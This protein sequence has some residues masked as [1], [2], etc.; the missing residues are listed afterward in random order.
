MANNMALYGFR[1]QRSRF[2]VLELTERA[3]V[4]SAYQAAPSAINVDLRPGDPVVKVSDGTVALAAAG[5]ATYGI[6]AGIGQYFDGEVMRPGGA[7]LPGGTTW[8]TLSERIS[9]VHIIP[10]AGQVF[11]ID[12]D[13][14]TTAT[15]EAA[16]RAFIGENCDISINAVSGDKRAYPL[17]DISTHETS[18]NSRVWRIVDL[19]LGGNLD[20]SG[21]RVKLLVTAA[22][23]QQA[24]FAVNGV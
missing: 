18:G 15:T 16:Y 20:F 14:A 4:A 7:S 22:Q 12:C 23:V 10:V 3:Y 24:P 5:N 8:G 1:W 2:D 17:L 21:T 19:A 9:V 13:D 11:E 6:V